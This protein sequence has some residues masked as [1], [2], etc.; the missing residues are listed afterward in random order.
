M[1]ATVLIQ[2]AYKIQN[3]KYKVHLCVCISPRKKSMQNYDRQKKIP[4]KSDPGRYISGIFFFFG[5]RFLSLQLQFSV[6]CRRQVR[7]CRIPTSFSKAVTLRA[8]F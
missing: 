3:T 4:F 5:S 7:H 8:Q 2:S 1:F 6:L